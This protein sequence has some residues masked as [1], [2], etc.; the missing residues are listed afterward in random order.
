[1]LSSTGESP[2]H[3]S[4]LER[5]RYFGD[6]RV[7]REVG[8]A[9]TMGLGNASYFRGRRVRRMRDFSLPGAQGGRGKGTN[10]TTF[11][12]EEET[13]KGVWMSVFVDD[14]DEVYKQCVAA[15]LDITLPP[16]DMPWNVRETHLR[17]PDGHVFR[18]GKGFECAEKE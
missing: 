10:T 9:E 3:Y 16:T 14:V 13:D 7:V 12:E 2:R 1:M 18:V 6:V 8:L 11:G 17:H 4:D 15:G 5:V